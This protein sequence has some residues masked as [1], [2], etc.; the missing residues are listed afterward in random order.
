MTDRPR[1][2]DSAL[3]PG[4]HEPLIDVHAHFLHA[5]CGRTDWQRVNAARMRAGQRIGIRYHVGSVLG[6]FGHRSPTYF[7]SPADTVE[8]NDAMY[9]TA[10]GDDAHIRAYVAVNPNDARLALEEIGRG[11]AKGAIGLKLAA[12]R[13]ADSPL[14]DDL[15]AAA[16][17]QGYPVLHHI[18]QWRRVEWPSQEA[19]DGVELGRLAARHPSVSF[20]LAHIGGGGDYMHSYAAVRDLPNVYLD[21]SG[22]GVDR[23]ML[24]AAFDAVGAA[25]VVWGADITLCTGLAKLRAIELLGLSAQ[26]LALVRSGNA[27]RIFPAGSFPGL[28]I[29]SGAQ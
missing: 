7:Q 20:I 25:R 3:S 24:D 26:E 5:G 13:R 27:Q 11:A 12:A 6:S 2:A 10:R 21:T 29:D 22:S 16:G 23:G 1:A 17:E 18:W 19:S 28:A 8:G 14:L 15:V 9:A 4:A